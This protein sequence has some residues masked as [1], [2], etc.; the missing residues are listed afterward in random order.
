MGP[1]VDPLRIRDFVRLPSRGGSDQ[2][3][4]ASRYPSTW[5]FEDPL[6]QVVQV[7][8]PHTQGAF[9]DVGANT[10]YYSALAG[11]LD[12]ERRVVAFE[13]VP[14]IAEILRE[15]LTVSRIPA[16]IHEVALSDEIG[17]A[18][19]Y[20]PSDEHGLVETS[21]SL[22]ADVLGS[23]VAT[24]L[25]ISLTT[26]DAV[27]AG[28]ADERV[29]FVKMDV[30]TFE[31][32]VL[33]G[34]HAVV[35]RD[36]PLLIIEVLGEAAFE[37]LTAFIT[38]H[39]YA[40]ISLR[41][42]LNVALEPALRFISD[43]WNQLLVPKERTEEILGLLTSAG[44]AD[45]KPVP[46]SWAECD[47]VEDFLLLQMQVAADTHTRNQLL[48]DERLRE[49]AAERDRLRLER[50]QVQQ[51]LVRQE[52]AHRELTA[53]KEAELAALRQQHEAVIN[54]KSWRY[55]SKLR[56]IVGR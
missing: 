35:R 46:A 40:I 51:E 45:H 24:E 44:Q 47:G 50:D 37:D 30:E 7:L 55:T 16:Q 39:D 19:I 25:E 11:K 56:G 3:S 33:G 8:L 29:G 36:R 18:T 9:Y 32:K 5:D 28:N 53:L 17:T 41:P 6:P 13:P 12:P 10:G 49:V 14:Y 2:I 54:S 52:I 15:N 26:L 21:A 48:H 22:R 38:G 4:D 43:G 1:L 42:G 34:A 23:R 27:N 20:L 31:H